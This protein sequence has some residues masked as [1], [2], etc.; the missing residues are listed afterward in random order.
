MHPKAY[1]GSVGRRL[2]IDERI[3]GGVV[4]VG[5]G[6]VLVEV[7]VTGARSSRARALARSGC[8]HADAS[9]LQGIREE[10]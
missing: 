2:A 10:G 8:S 1:A 7:R 4:I 3:S 6:T 5:F 9:G